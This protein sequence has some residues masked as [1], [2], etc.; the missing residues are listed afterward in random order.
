MEV[1]R[2]R[3]FCKKKDIVEAFTQAC[4]EY[5]ERNILFQNHVMSFPGAVDEVLDHVLRR[6]LRDSTGENFSID[7]DQA[8]IFVNI[9]SKL[10]SVPVRL[11]KDDTIELASSSSLDQK[12][13]K[14]L[15]DV[16]MFSDLAEELFS[17]FFPVS[18]KNFPKV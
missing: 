3:E 10:F 2:Q 13:F 17:E 8:K 9:V 14:E 5:C 6:Q 1:E 18:I 16:R 12:Q 11:R 15:L 4:I 7:Q